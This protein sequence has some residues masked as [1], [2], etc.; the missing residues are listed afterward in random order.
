MLCM[1]Q[2]GPMKENIW[3]KQGF[4]NVLYDLDLI[5]GNSIEGHWT[6]STQ[7]WVKIHQ[8]EPMGR[9]IFSRQVMCNGKTDY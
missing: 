3:S 9:E 6:P 2:I 8:I 4:S 5:P 1:S 7:R